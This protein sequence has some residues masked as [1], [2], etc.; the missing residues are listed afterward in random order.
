MSA[1]AYAPAHVARNVDCTTVLLDDA[2]PQWD[3]LPLP[4]APGFYSSR[5]WHQA[6]RAL[7]GAA[8]SVV[9]AW[10]AAPGGHRL[11][12]VVPVSRYPDDPA[13]PANA[14][15]HPARLF[16]AAG[17]PAQQWGPITLLGT[18]AGYETAP[19]C[20]SGQQAAWAR[21]AAQAIPAE[22]TAVMLHLDEPAAVAVHARF[23]DAPLL[24]TSARSVL[25]LTADSVEEHD[26]QLPSRKR[27]V[28]HKETARLQEAG[29]AITVKDLADY[30]I[31]QLIELQLLT[32]RRH[33]APDD[34]AA[35]QTGFR[36]ILSSPC[37]LQAARVFLAHDRHGEL[38][39]YHLAFIHDGTLLVRNIGLDYER[40]THGEYFAVMVH[41]PLRYAFEHG[42]RQIDFGLE[43][44]SQKLRRG[45]R[46]V[47]LW[48][49]LLRPPAGWTPAHTIACNRRRAAELLTAMGAHLEPDEAERLRTIGR[50]GLITP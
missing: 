14:F 32:Q 48:S 29:S 27:Y 44:F 22:G 42:L 5:P 13:T 33:N 36:R 2:P 39:A 12:A 41:A 1:P 30:D 38:V 45:A 11:Q 17:L 37:L 25:T 4:G 20:A 16:S 19:I 9:L 28:A 6:N 40:A 8:E 50:T 46:P 31:N 43:A 34:P 23:P 35:F 49:A 15:L 24:L 7:S 3:E 47:L 26:A 21:A 18:T 10:T